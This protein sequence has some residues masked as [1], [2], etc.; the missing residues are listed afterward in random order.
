MLNFAWP[1]VIVLLPLP[2]LFHRLLPPA[3][4][5]QSALKAP[6]FAELDQL[7]TQH[8]AHSYYKISKAIALLCIWLLVITAAARP[9]SQHLETVLPED[10][11]ALYLA[12][13][14][15][16]SMRI[17][18]MQSQ[19]QPHTRADFVKTLIKELIKQRPS[20][21]I[22]LIVFASQ[23]FLQSPLTRDHQTLTQWV[24]EAQP[25]M[26]GEYT[27]IGDAVGLSIQKLRE[28][29]SDN[30]V[31]IL[32]T[33]GANNSGVMPPITAAKLAAQYGIRLYTIG[34]G[35][36]AAESGNPTLHD[37]DE[38]LLQEMATLTQGQYLRLQT[39]EQLNE[40]LAFF[41]R[42]EPSQQPAQQYRVQEL[43]PW[44]LFAAVALAA[45]LALL[46]FVR[47]VYNAH[48]LRRA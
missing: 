30:K 29:N 31:A 8:D 42:I 45:C 26:A 15:S 11:R 33:D 13:D 39:Q 24:N 47:F 34:V 35:S 7:A 16:N 43:Y 18:D 1:W 40:L 23:P 20:D 41:Q 37:L 36:T 48:Q 27:A 2:W 4:P 6:F 19:G 28:Q 5:Q 14:I 38:P 22:G 3:I 32:I 17:Q 25:G 9:Q 44:F 10:A 21:R 12:I 46:S